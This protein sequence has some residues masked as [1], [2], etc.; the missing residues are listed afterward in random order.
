MSETSSYGFW[1][2][3]LPEQPEI[4]ASE[5]VKK[6]IKD[7]TFCLFISCKSNE[8]STFIEHNSEKYVAVTVADGAY[9]YVT[10]DNCE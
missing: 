1:Y 7:G 10:N 2:H 3:L 8:M 4:F 6:Q 9:P 5:N